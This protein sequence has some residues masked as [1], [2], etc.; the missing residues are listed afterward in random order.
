MEIFRK[1]VAESCFHSSFDDDDS[2]LDL[3]A[4]DYVIIDDSDEEDPTFD[5]L[6]LTRSRLSSLSLKKKSKPRIPEGKGDKFVLDPPVLI[7]SDLKKKSKLCV[8]KGMEDK[9]D[10]E[11]SDS[12][13]FIPPELNAADQ[14]SFEA[15]EKMIHSGMIDKLKLDQCKIYLRKHGLRLSGNKYI[16]LKRIKEHLEIIDGGGERKYPASSFIL[17]CKGDACT[18][19]VVMFEQN[20]Y[21]MYSIVSRSASGPSCGKRTVAGR[22]VKESY[23][24]EKQQ[25]TFT[26]EVLWSQGEKPLPPLHPLLIK[27]RNLYRLRTMRQRWEDESERQ[28]MLWEKHARGSLARSNRDARLVEKEKRKTLRTSKT[29]NNNSKR[30]CQPKKNASA[31]LTDVQVQH[32][33]HDDRGWGTD[34]QFHSRAPLPHSFRNGEKENQINLRGPSSPFRGGGISRRH[35]HHHHGEALRCNEFQRWQQPCRFYAQGRCN[36]GER[37]KYL[38]EG[39]VEF[40]R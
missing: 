8:P 4:E 17:N 34:H 6:E 24:A 22:I 2:D 15:V 28:K 1:P 14:K 13:E 23:G 33:N 19:D 27:G 9:S 36:Y 26:I 18:G 11:E 39:R 10:E 5:P 25:H 3:D 20:V 7:R 37:C 21:E 40:Q 29:I 31:P 32:R 16:I 35:H 30:T 12:V 38:H